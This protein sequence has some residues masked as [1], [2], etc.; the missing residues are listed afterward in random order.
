[1][2]QAPGAPPGSG[3]VARCAPVV[4]LQRCMR[5]D[6]CMLTRGKTGHGRR[7]KWRCA[8]FAAEQDRAAAVPGARMLC[9]ASP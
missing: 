4:R 6:G 8:V 2:K 3:R 9:R 7:T 1:V 5:P